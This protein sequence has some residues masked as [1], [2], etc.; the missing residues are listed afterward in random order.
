MQDLHVGQRS[1]SHVTCSVCGMMYTCGFHDDISEHSQFHHRYVSGVTFP[2]RISMMGCG[3]VAR[4]PLPPSKRTSGVHCHTVVYSIGHTLSWYV[5]LQGWKRERVVGKHFDG[6]IVMI[7]PTDPRH[8]L[9]K[10][11]MYIYRT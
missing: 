1:F 7:L 11:Y 6:R 9:K 2:V 10:V 5:A 3:D 8:H 4:M